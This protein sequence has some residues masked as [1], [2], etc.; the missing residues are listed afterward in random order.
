MSG[1]TFLSAQL[2]RGGQVSRRVEARD[3]FGIGREQDPEESN[4][5]PTT[6]NLSLTSSPWGISVSQALSFL[7][8]QHE[9]FALAVNTL[10][11]CS[12]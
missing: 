4:F 3:P 9:H 10:H 11:R 1:I 8:L 2:C 5:A 12:V 6:S 7:N